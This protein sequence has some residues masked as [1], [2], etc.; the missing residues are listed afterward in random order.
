ML[1]PTQSH[2]CN[3]RPNL[4]P[5]SSSGLNRL[6]AALASTTASSELG[7]G[8]M[9]V[10]YLAHDLRHE[11][12]VALKVL[13][14]ELAQTLGTDRFL[15]EIKLGARLQHPH[16]VSVH[17]SGEV[18]AGSE[19]PGCVWSACRTSRARACGTTCAASASFRSTRFEVAVV[20]PN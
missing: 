14:P 9:N 4:S 20:R 13:H 5:G 16:M 12:P 2:G 17:D 19:G 15:R 3:L 6:Q 11:R 7:R 18:H 8:G 1:W 10:V